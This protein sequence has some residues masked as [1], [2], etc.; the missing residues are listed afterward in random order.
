MA[1]CTHITQ[2]PVKKQTKHIQTNN[3]YQVTRGHRDEQCK[4]GKDR[5]RE[6]N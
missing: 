3:K 4:I 6:K 2:A 1:K 5:K